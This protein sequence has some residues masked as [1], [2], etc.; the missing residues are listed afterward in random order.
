MNVAAARLPLGPKEPT[1]LEI[2]I[3]MK[4]LYMS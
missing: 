1:F 4:S 3:I 2:R